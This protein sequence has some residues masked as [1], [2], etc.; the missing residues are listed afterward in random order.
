MSMSGPNN[1]LCLSCSKKVKCNHK[2]ITC[3]I[4]KLFIHKKCTNLKRK[5]ILKIQPG[6][7]T[8]INC[9]LNLT[10]AESSVNEIPND[11]DHTNFIITDE[12]FS[13]YDKMVFN[14]VRYKNKAIDNEINENQQCHN[15]TYLTPDQFNESSQS[16]KEN[17]LSIINVNIRSLNKNFDKLKECLKATNHNFTIIGL[18]ETHLKEKPSD[19]YSIPG[20]NFEFK[21]RVNREKGGVGIYV[22]QSV[23]YKLRSDLCHATPNVET[24][25]IEIEQDNAKNIIVGVVYRAHTA[26]DNFIEDFHPIL[27]QINKENKPNYIMGDY[28]IDL[29]KVDTDR[30]SRDYLNLIYS[31]SYTPTIIKPTRITPSSATLI[32]NILTNNQVTVN[33]VILVT[34]ITDHLPTILSTTINLQKK[35]V[36]KKEQSYKRSHTD[37]NI[38]YFKQ[39]LSKVNWNEKLNGVNVDEDY[40][41]FNETFTKLY[42]ECI[43]LKKCSVNRKKEPLSPWITKG[44]LKSINN[45]NKLY[46]KYK[47]IPN[48]ENLQK[49]KMYRNKLDSLIRKSKRQYF[50]NKFNKSKNDMQKTWKTINNI[51]GRNKQQKVQSQFV[52]SDG[53]KITNPQTISND[54][55]DFF[56]NIGPKLASEIKS[57]G[58]DYYDYMNSP[59]QNSCFMSPITED[60][61]VKVISK[62]DQNKSPGHDNIGNYIVKRVANEISK[63]LTIIFNQSISTGVV[64]NQ[65]KTAKVIPLYKKDNAEIYSNYRPVSLLPCFSK[66]LERLVFN[67]SMQHIDKHGI[68]NSKQFGFRS[69]HSTSMAVTELVDKINNAIEKGETTVAVYLDLSKAFDTIDHN[70]LLYKLEHYGFRGIVLEW[71]KSY[72]HNRTQYV[73]FNDVKSNPLN[74]LC[75]VPQGSILG[76]LLFLIYINDIINASSLLEFILFADDTTL[77][78]SHKNIS[79]KTDIINKELE[80]ITNWFKANKLSVNAS[81]TNFMIMGTHQKT[82]K[83]FDE[84]NITLDGTQLTRVNQTKFLG[85]I[86]DENLTWKDHIDAISKTISRNVGV[87]NKLKHFIPNRILYSLY[88]TLILPY[89]SYGILAWGATCKIYMDKIFKLQKRAMRTISNSHFRSHSAPI[90]KNLKVLNVYDMYKVDLGVFMYKHFNGQLPQIFNEYFNKF[91]DIHDR[92]TRNNNDYQFMKNKTAMASRGVRSSGPCLWNTLSP[93]IKMS[94]NIKQFKK[95]FKNELLNTYD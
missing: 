50:E 7:F 13:K 27:E 93:N 77:S 67:R 74:I 10:K 63:P 24:C 20:Y 90:F 55:N 28:N 1:D 6:E 49:Y 3:N 42:D 80:E 4:C 29:L 52:N 18:S 57:N 61:V 91:T 17:E 12:D 70:I 40:N 23:N 89:I 94:I 84:V 31:H 68:L 54:F 81:K 11:D 78:Y 16:S 51:T 30:P 64:P 87:L 5:D 58:K 38:N 25:F 2:D 32:D 44:L 72:L 41:V 56:V 43:P 75:G 83:C 66:I 14:P 33:S 26:I 19:Y 79:S 39:K 69:N 53:E 48:D 37:C 62:F 34:D 35:K 36:P 46:K 73:Y 95:Q 82:T 86:I 22:R 45:K 85:V 71:F 76:P 59:L 65:L 15:C 8:C 47:K 88:C 9:K 92:D 21:N 60:E